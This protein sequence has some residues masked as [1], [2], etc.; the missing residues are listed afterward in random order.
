MKK[1][2]VGWRRQEPPQ[3]HKGTTSRL[4]KVKVERRRVENIK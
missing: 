2:E 4:G 1:E 3:E